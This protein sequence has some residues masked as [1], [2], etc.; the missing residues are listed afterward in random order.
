MADK[1]ES[2]QTFGRKVRFCQFA[3]LSPPECSAGFSPSPLGPA[4]GS[5]GAVCPRADRP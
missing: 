3:D 5:A 4:P 1:I 2:V